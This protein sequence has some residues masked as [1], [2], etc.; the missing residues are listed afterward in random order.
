M[1]KNE[2]VGTIHDVSCPACGNHVAVDFYDGG[3]QPLATIA[4]P[5]SEE[6]AREM[7]RLPLDFVRCVDCGHVFNRSF[8]YALVPYSAKPNLMF[9]RAPIWSMHIR[10]TVED[11]LAYLPESPVVVEIGCGEGHFLRALAEARPTGRYIGFDPNGLINTQGCIVGRQELFDPAVHLE[12]LKPDLLVSRHVLEHLMNPLGFLQ[13]INFC[14]RWL[15]L[16]PLL[17]LEV[18]C[19]DNVFTSGRVA[20]FYFEHNSHFSTASFSRMLGRCGDVELVERGYGGEVVYGLAKLGGQDNSVLR[21]REAIEF[22][23][24]AEATRETVARQFAEL[25]AA[26]RQVAIWGGTGKGA[27]FIQRY[28]LDIARFPLVVDSDPDKVGTFVPGTG[29]RIEFRDILAGGGTDIVVIP[30]Q[31]RARDIVAEMK[32][33]GITA[34]LVL[35]EHQGQLI[36]YHSADHPYR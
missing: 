22:R 12:E 19:I 33:C 7:V 18:P 27:A 25:S 29:Q 21:A 30:T 31:W 23:D 2:L 36:D 26:G 3:R 8:D 32:S 6:E 11:L 24:A 28:G 4:W 15:G 35:I 9:N 16:S 34:N 17:F 13:R 5:S 10:K 1:M 20:D 14:S